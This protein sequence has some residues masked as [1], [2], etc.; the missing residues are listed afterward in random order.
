MF[1]LLLITFSFFQFDR[2]HLNVVGIV[3]LFVI[4]DWSLLL[5]FVLEVGPKCLAHVAIAK[6]QHQKWDEEIGQGVPDYV[7]LAN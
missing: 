5:L 6:Q 7:S 3:R 4:G 2:I 1:R